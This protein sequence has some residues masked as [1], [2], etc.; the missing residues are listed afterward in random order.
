M[1]IAFVLMEMT[2]TIMEM[3]K[4]DSGDEQQWKWLEI[5]DWDNLKM[6][7]ILN[8]YVEIIWSKDWKKHVPSL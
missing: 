2:Q 6:E 4:C 1:E 3:I 8:W 7:T 5:I